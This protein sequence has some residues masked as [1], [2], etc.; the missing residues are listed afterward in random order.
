M[1]GL[2]IHA[3]RVPLREA[4]MEPWEIMISESQERMLSIVEP[5]KLDE[6]REVCG[7]WDLDC[8]VIGEVT[9]SKMLRIYWHGEMVGDIPARRLADE[10]PVIRTPSVKPAYLVDDP[11]AVTAARLPG[12]GRPGRGA[13][14]AARRAQHRR[15][16]LGLGAVRLHR[17]GQ[18]HADPGRRR[19]R[20]PPQGRL[21]RHRLRH[22]L[23]RTSLLPRPVPWR[24]GG[25]RRGGPQPELRRRPARRRHGLPQLRQPR[26]GRD[27][28]AVRA[29][30]RGHGRG[31]RGARHARRQRQRQ[32]LQRELRPGDLP[33][34]AGR[35]AGRLR[36]RLAAG[37]PLLQGRGRR[38][39]AARPRGGLGGRRRSTRRCT[40]ARSRAAC[41]TSTWSSRR[42][43]RRRCAKRSSAACSRARTTA[44]RAA[45]RWRW[46]SAPSAAASTAACASSS[47]RPPR[48]RASAAPTWRSARACATEGA[49]G[50][51]DLA[52]FGEA[53]SR[54]VVTVAPDR[55]VRARGAGRR[56]AAPRPRQRDRR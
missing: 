45:S 20:A 32:L 21:A 17:A 33:H 24:Q 1:V 7:R 26:E 30:R 48:G 11:V 47:R 36:R 18:H 38:D 10:A 54:V 52:L 29:G 55:L 50:R 40:S 43:C 51:P 12:A 53:P 8:T 2:D 14:G 56:H 49:A 31:L 9:D 23:Q 35:H 42:R 19:R 25:G 6:V 46:P 13:G 4:D 34:A 16:A 44:P 3:D 41:P 15:Q 5:G 28:L 27:L 37:R 22:R 39:R